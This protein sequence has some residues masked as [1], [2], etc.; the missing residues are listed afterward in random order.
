MAVLQVRALL[1]LDRVKGRMH[2]NAHYR[3]VDAWVL[4]F[5][6]NKRGRSERP[7]PVASHESAVPRSRLGYYVC[8]S[9]MKQSL[10]ALDVPQTRILA[11]RR[12]ETL[13]QRYSS[14]I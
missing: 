4:I 10:S 13:P 2:E 6:S 5:R 9:Y 7:R 12:R 1:K 8:L 14:S 3:S 11:R